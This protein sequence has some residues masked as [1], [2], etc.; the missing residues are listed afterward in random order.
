MRIVKIS[1]LIAVSCAFISGAT[2]FWVSQKVQKAE[3]DIARLEKEKNSEEEMMRVLKAEWD[4][5]NRPDRL[6]TLAKEHL[7]YGAIDSDYILDN[8]S[9]LPNKSPLYTPHYKHSQINYPKEQKLENI[10]ENLTYEE[11]KQ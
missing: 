8:A 5:L 11:D 4:Y 3:R 10:I 1:T 2:L 9:L 7:D 6:E